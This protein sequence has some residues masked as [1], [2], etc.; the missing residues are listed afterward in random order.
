VSQTGI[1]FGETATYICDTGF[2]LM[3]DTTQT[4]QATGLWSGNAPTCQSMLQF[5]NLKY[6]HIKTYGLTPFNSCGL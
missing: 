1:H 6:N 3:G 5:L 4:C 2:T